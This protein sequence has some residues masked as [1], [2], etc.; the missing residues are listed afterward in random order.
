M[1]RAFGADYASS[2]AAA[3][4]ALSG[5]AEWFDVSDS[6]T[7]AWLAAPSAKRQ[8]RGLGADAA[9]L[10]ANSLVALKH[11]LNPT[12]GTLVASFA[13]HEYAY[14]VWGRDG[15][16]AALMLI[17]AGHS[18]EGEAYLR[19]LA[20]AQMRDGDQGFHTNYDWFT[21]APIGFVE[22]Q[23]DSAGAY[24]LALA[25]AYAGADEPQRNASL[26]LEP[27][28]QARV[29]TLEAFFLD[30]VDARTGLA[31]PDYSIW[32]ES[33]DGRTGQPLPTSFFAFTQAMAYA[34][35]YAAARIEALVYGDAQRAAALAAR[36]TALCD[37]INAHLWMPAVG[38]YAR[39]IWSDTYELDA[40][41]DASSAAVVFAGCAGAARGAQHLAALRAN[42]TR[43]GAG[44]A[45]YPD[46][47]FF[48]DSKY[49]PGG[50][51]VGAPSPPWGVCT[52]FTAWAELAAGAAGAAAS[53]DARLAWMV[54]HAAPGAM[55]VGEAID[56]VS[57]R[58]V[59]SSC[60]DIYEYAGVYAYTVL[61]SQSLVPSLDPRALL[62]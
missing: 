52:M 3:Q 18:A 24:L 8:P 26:L 55:P 14:K 5:T 21:G 54:A 34:G 2:L 50:R 56:G 10:Y 15:V 35:V 16:F 51:E 11:S 60:P 57:G 59:M 45:R 13:P 19:W 25:Y 22:P 28:V 17:A 37:A 58:F 32:E 20:T 1:Y 40:R 12:L 6:A 38:A 42:L 48:Y 7:R 29:R 46:D 30:N 23:Y 4:R 47:P 9:A 49:N 39:G 27:A 62:G 33:S 31:P 44:M 41:L 36:A 53:V 61:L 43:L